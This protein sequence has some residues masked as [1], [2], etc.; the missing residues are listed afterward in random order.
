LDLT[1]ETC[2]FEHMEEIAEE[3]REGGIGLG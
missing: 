3:L 1:V 2:S